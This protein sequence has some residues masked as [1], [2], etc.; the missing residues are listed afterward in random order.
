MRLLHDTSTQY[1]S[2]HSGLVP[3]PSD[4]AQILFETQAHLRV[5]EHLSFEKNWIQ[6]STV[7][8]TKNNDQ[9]VSADLQQPLDIL[10]V[11]HNM[12]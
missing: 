7:P 3:R 10:A 4:Y 2:I 6:I 9:K 1:E 8:K 12:L 11:A 5:A